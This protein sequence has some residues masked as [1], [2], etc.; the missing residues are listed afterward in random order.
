MMRIQ[1]DFK[2]LLTLLNSHRVEYILVGAYALAHH[3]APRFTGNLDLFIKPDTRNAQRRL[4]ALQDFGFGSV[5][6][7]VKDFTEP[8]QVIQLGVPPVRVDL[9]TSISGVS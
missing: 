8:D 3:G 6:L 2:E 1:Q 5:G 9:I 4:A 7:E